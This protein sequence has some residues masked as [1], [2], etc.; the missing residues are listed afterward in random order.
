MDMAAGELNHPAVANLDLAV[1]GRGTVANDKMVG[2]T[3][4][5]APDVAVIVVKD[6]GVP[7]AS[8]A[9]VHHDVFPAIPGHSGVINGSPHSGSQVSPATIVVTGGDALV[10]AA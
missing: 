5:H 4:R 7:L 2:E 6:P 9:I 10:L 1:A 3:I 8:P